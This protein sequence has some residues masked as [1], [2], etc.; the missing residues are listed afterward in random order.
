MLNDSVNV[1]KLL[2]IDKI[3][4]KNSRKLLDIAENCIILQKMVKT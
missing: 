3:Y 1:Q 4:L 2:T